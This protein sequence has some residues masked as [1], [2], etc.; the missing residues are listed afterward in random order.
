MDAY[1]CNAIFLGGTS[2][3]LTRYMFLSLYQGSVFGVWMGG[4]V[5]AEKG[6]GEGMELVLGVHL[7]W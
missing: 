7:C 5:G 2:F 3:Y 4:F 1:F 6:G